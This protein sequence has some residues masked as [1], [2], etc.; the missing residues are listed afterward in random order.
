MNMYVYFNG[1]GDIQSISPAP[2]LDENLPSKCLFALFPISDVEGFLLAKKNTFD[3]FVKTDNAVDTKYTIVKKYTPTLSQVRTLASFMT[4]ITEVANATI[5]IGHD[6]K[7]HAV[8]VSVGP[9]I[10]AVD[11]CYINET[12]FNKFSNTHCI[13]LYFTKQ[14][15]PYF[16]IHTIS[17]NPRKL[18]AAGTL[19]F[20]HTK[21]L[22]T[23]SLYAQQVIRGYSYTPRIKD[24]I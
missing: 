17:L 11:T 10:T 16:L 19:R 12:I 4:E 22:S 8:I 6:P 3:F 15:D 2:L 23:A 18:L 9:D 21:N 13:E 20:A 7:E 1:A 24:D 5:I 14:N